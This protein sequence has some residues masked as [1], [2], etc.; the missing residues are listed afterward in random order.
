METVKLVDNSLP[1]EY[2]DGKVYNLADP[3]AFVIEL[4]QSGLLTPAGATSDAPDALAKLRDKTQ[5]AF[6]FPAL[7]YPQLLQILEA[8]KAFVEAL[9]KKTPLT[10]TSPNA[11]ASCHKKMPVG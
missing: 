9:Q 2:T 3:I 1:V 7:S 5:S 11:T 6:G 10:P 4:T 8:I